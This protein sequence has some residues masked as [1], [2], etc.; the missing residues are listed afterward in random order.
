MSA[1]LVWL[2]LRTRLTGASIAAIA[3][4]A[5]SIALALARSED[6]TLTRLLLTIAPLGAA[7]VVG[8]GTRSPL[9]ESEWT[10]AAPLPA[11]RVGHLALL[12]GWGGL[13]LAVAGAFEPTDAAVWTLLRNG[14][15]YA[16]LALLGARLLG[17]GVSWVPALAYGGG[18]WLAFVTAGEP[19]RSWMWPLHPA[20]DGGALYLALGLLAAGLL[21]V[22]LA[23]PRLDAAEVN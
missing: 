8:V 3:V 5:A 1:R 23:G 6:A 14:A 21:V 17:A 12:A 18:V 16:G 9:G 11:L 19:P 13:T 7:V 2:F 15:G 10:A 4:V 22:A 20:G